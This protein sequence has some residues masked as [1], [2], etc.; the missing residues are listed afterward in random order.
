MIPIF[1]VM[2]ILAPK[3]ALSDEAQ[4][5]DVLHKCDDALTAQTQVSELQKQIIS[6]Q[7]KRY[8]LQTQQLNTE[9][10]WKPIAIGAGVIAIIETL[11]LVLKK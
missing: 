4:C 1:I 6:D 11:L 10:I 3:V 2:M 8:D 9:K 7:D 5:R